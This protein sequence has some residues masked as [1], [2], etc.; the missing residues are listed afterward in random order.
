MT[1]KIK[2]ICNAVKWFDKVNGN[3]YHSVR[4]TRC[5][6][7]K[8]IV[9]L[10]APYEYGYGDQYRYTALAAMAKA[11]WLPSKYIGK[12]DRG[13]TLASSYERENNYPIMWNVSNGLKREMIANG[14]LKRRK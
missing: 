13:A 11:K 6:D 1:Q 5:K 3:T 14:T 8:V 9:G 4:I 7:G 12:N 2:F 10:Y